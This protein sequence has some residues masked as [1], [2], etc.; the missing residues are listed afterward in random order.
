[1]ES[2]VQGRCPFRQCLVK[3]R[4]R[5]RAVGRRDLQLQTFL[6]QRAR[7]AIRNM[8]TVSTFRSDFRRN[9]ICA[10]SSGGT[11]KTQSLLRPLASLA[12]L[13]LDLRR[14]KFLKNPAIF[15]EITG[16]FV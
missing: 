10:S 4:G 16:F 15:L 7:F 5:R 2:G 8:A 9:A 3:L 11:G 14:R 13:R 6:K 1:K 12:G